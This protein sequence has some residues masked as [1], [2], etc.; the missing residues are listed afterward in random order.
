MQLNKWA[1]SISL[2][3]IVDNMASFLFLQATTF[4]HQETK[5]LQKTMVHWEQPNKA[6]YKQVQPTINIS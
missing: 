1:A 4:F 2:V 3:A 5:V 6:G